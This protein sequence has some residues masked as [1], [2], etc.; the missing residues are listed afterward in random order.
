M[1]RA[2]VRR[3]LFYLFDEDS[4]QLKAAMDKFNASGSLEVGPALVRSPP[5]SL[6][7]GPD[8]CVCAVCPPPSESA[9]TRVP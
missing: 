6:R 5:S 7:V 8:T 3:Y 4:K 1:A 2:C 9:R